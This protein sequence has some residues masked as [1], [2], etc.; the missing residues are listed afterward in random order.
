MTRGVPI[1]IALLTLVGCDH[2]ETA[3]S[4]APLAPSATPPRI[5]SGPPPDAAGPPARVDPCALPRTVIGDV[6]P[7][8]APF[9]RE[10][11]PSD[12]STD[13][14]SD[15]V[16]RAPKGDT[17]FVA[18]DA[19]AR[20]ERESHGGGKASGVV[21]EF[22]PSA[23]RYLDRIDAHLHLYES[24]RETLRKNGFV[25]LDRLEEESYATA[26]HDIFQEQLPV[27]VGIDAILHSVF[28]A[29]GSVLENVEHHDLAP[30]LARML[31]R[32][33]KTL[34]ASLARYGPET[35][36]DLAT[37]LSVADVLL[38]ELPSVR[39]GPP[40]HPTPHDEL[41]SMLVEKSTGDAPGLEEVTLFG[42]TR[43]IDFS[44]LTPRGHYAPHFNYTEPPLDGYFRAMTWL[45]RF[46]WN[47]V[48]R[49]CRSSQPGAVD[50]EETPREERDAMA[51]A[52]L[53]LR[54]GVLSDLDHF[55]RVY[56]VF[57]GRREDVS[58]PDLL[59]MMRAN[60]LDPRARD[61]PEKL[62]AAIGSRFARTTRTHFM[63]EGS[64]T[65]PA[66]ATLIGPRIVPD[67][68]PLTR[69]VHD[70]VPER[71]HIRAAD[72]GYLLGHD[73]ANEYFGGD[74]AGFPSLPSALA[75]ARAELRSGL[76]GK[77]DLY[78]LWLEA[79]VHL[80]ERPSGTT[81]SFMR[82]PAYADLSLNS[83]LVGYGQIRHNYVL[84]AAQG[85]D[86]YG[87]EIP[88]GYVEPALGT[89]DALLAYVRAARSTDSAAAPYWKRVE[90]VLGML[91]G[92]VVTELA[93]RRLSDAQRRW[94][95]MIAEH[96]PRDG[97]G[98]DSGAPPKWTGWYFDLFP[99]RHHGAEH[100][101]AFIADY[102][103]LSNIEKVAYLGA[104]R[105]RLAVFMVDVNGEPRAMV[106]PVAKG[107]ELLGPLAV[108]LDDAKALD[109]PGKSAPWLASYLAP[110]VATP[111]LA[112]SDAWCKPD[113]ERVMIESAAPL[114]SVTVTL[115]DHHGDPIS[116]AVTQPVGPNPALFTFRAQAT[117]AHAAEGLWVRVNDPKLGAPGH[118][119]V[120]LVYG[121]RNY[122]NVADLGQEPVPL[123]HAFVPFGIGGFEP[124]MPN[125]PFPLP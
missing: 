123:H 115:L 9:T 118:D 71:K 40:R 113:E 100:M 45:S 77:T 61:A 104:D 22:A 34:E 90:A 24:E 60:G 38:G 72:V 6:R 96:I 48:S 80:A 121:V 98:G 21:A 81:P 125:A 37:Y 11:P 52:D 76:V 106:G 44:Q 25:A 102:F 35:S 57:A 89:Y 42:R 70:A 23:P 67:T 84:L 30:R 56:T 55:D 31:P 73:R 91:R 18:D 7:D 43:M 103:T 82:S 75:K 105:P 51:L 108:R 27:F 59:A 28:V 63:P 95:G 5:A 15:R 69:V 46:E 79:V 107:Y 13:P 99:D 58:V 112:M 3:K 33:I 92:I 54:A 12:E 32:L 111:E 20:A 53:V 74:L 68:A 124:A 66:I 78:S 120:D 2:A 62:R 50:A 29:Q 93:G 86:S 39:P 14:F 4:P 83:A 94:L 114:A 110:D 36:A 1:A 19:I 26:Y 49:S 64:T 117:Q 8:V 109:M 47:L 101:P 85:Y 10:P 116:T 16:A 17:C 119:H 41:A 87:C 88:D 122:T 65:L 97:Y